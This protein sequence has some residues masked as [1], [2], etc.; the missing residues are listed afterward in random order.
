MSKRKLLIFSLILFVVGG[1]SWFMLNVFG[2]E[3]YENI[4][5]LIMEAGFLFGLVFFLLAQV[6]GGRKAEDSVL[7]EYASRGGSWY[8]PT[9]LYILL[10]SVML[11]FLVIESLTFG[12][13]GTSKILS[14]VFQYN[15]TMRRALET[16]IVIISFGLIVNWLRRRFSK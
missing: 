14:E 4:L 13:S 5:S 10:A 2:F 12:V 8:K 9:Y 16:S 7:E 1:L 6:W 11:G 15:N 3:V